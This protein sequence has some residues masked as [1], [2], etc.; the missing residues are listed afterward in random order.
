MPL[1]KI[2]LC[3][4][5]SREEKKALLDAV[6]SALVNAF[7]IPEADR[8]QRLVEIEPENFKYPEG[9]TS[10]YTVIEMV[11]FPGR[12]LAAKRKLYK[13]IVENLQKLNIQT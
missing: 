3:K 1:V 4:G 10:N 9:K 2:S 6:H 8:N 13:N 11:V 5:R 12:S 7:E